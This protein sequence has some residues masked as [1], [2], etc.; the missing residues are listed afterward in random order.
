MA[1]DAYKT[2]D[3]MQ[4]VLAAVRASNLDWTT[5]TVSDSK[6]VELEKA[7]SQA[8]QDFAP[9]GGADPV[10]SQAFVTA[11]DNL[12][13]YLTANYTLVNGIYT[14]KNSLVSGKSNSM[15]YWA[16][17]LGAAAFILSH[18]FKKMNK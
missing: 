12:R 4:S 3:E 17:G 10:I 15:L 6:L 11:A 18:I 16:I 9:T 14:K 1:I 8:Y 2:N 7:Y 13:N 5:A